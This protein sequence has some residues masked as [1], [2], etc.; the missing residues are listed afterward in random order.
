MRS[1]TVASNIA[2]ILLSS[3]GPVYYAAFGFGRDFQPQ[4]DVLQHFADV[5]PVWALDVQRTLLVG[6]Q[7]DGPVKGISAM[8]SMHIVSCAIMALYGFT[9][10][11]WAGW[12]LTGFAAV[13][14]IGSVHLAW[15]YAIDGYLGIA[16]A[17]P[18]W[19]AARRLVDW[20]SRDSAGRPDAGA[21]RRTSAEPELVS[22][23]PTIRG[24]GVWWSRAGSNR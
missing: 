24:I 1:S 13:I 3:V 22:P 14:L 15:H 16:I 10:A 7:T 8:P 19:F 2:A 9:L 20:T 23:R 12:V 11:R 5:S 18:L 4:M 6:Y 21:G 17:V